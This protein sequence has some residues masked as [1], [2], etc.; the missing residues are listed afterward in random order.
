M[1]KDKDFSY[2]PFEGLEKLVKVGYAVIQPVSSKCSTGKTQNAVFSPFK[3]VIKQTDVSSIALD[4]S[5]LFIEAMRDVVPLNGSKTLNKP[6]VTPPDLHL[7]KVQDEQKMVMR[8]LKDIVAGEAKVPVVATPE[9]V[10]GIGWGADRY[11]V[12]RLH[13]G[14][15]SVQAYC[16]LHGMDLLSAMERCEEFVKGAIAEAKSC[17]A[18]IHGRGLSSRGRPVIKETVIHWLHS[19]PYRRYIIAFASAPEWDGG[20]GVT[21][22]LLRQRPAKRTNQ[23]T[24][25]NKIRG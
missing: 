9:F 21:Y 22:V 15:F 4:E 18:I 20:A 7:N 12:H 2:R 1:T 5:S 13:K 14:D 3:K 10:E 8:Q 11:L 19:G 16:D 23:K 17:V 25:Q 6:Q 24:G